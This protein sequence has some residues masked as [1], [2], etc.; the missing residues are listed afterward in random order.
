MDLITLHLRLALKKPGCALCRL[1][2]ETG[3]RYITGL[4][5]ENV[6]DMTTRTH[7]AHSLGLCPDHAWQLQA[8]EL[9]HWHNGLGTTII[10]NDL[11]ERVLRAIETTS[12]R[13]RHSIPPVTTRLENV[14]HRLRDWGT[15]G[16]WLSGLLPPPRPG[17]ALLAALTPTEPCR[18]CETEHRSGETYALWLARALTDPKFQALVTASDGICLPHLRQIL[19]LAESPAAVD[20]LTADTRRRLAQLHH[21]LSEYGRKQQWQYHTETV[22]PPEE[23][24]WARSIAFF[25][26]E[27]SPA[28][29]VRVQKARTDAL[30]LAVLQKQTNVPSAV[31][32]SIEKNIPGR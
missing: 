32:R 7:L 20:F 19:S 3:T 10:Y 1:R 23:T 2:Q 25:A 24:A 17:Q 30:W 14:R 5:H 31:A 15:V 26:G 13:H 11:T 29:S 18:V 12:A 9:D 28:S 8:I 27:A 22:S 21:R 4:L 6:N 16:Q